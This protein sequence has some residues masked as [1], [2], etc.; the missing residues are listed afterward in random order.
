MLDT[1]EKNEREH[2]EAGDASRIEKAPNADLD[3]Y[4]ENPELDARL[5]RKFDFHISS[6]GFSASGCIAT[7]ISFNVALLVFYIPYI[8]VDVPCN[9]LVK[10]LRAGIYLPSLITVWGIVCMC[11]GFITNFA[12]LIACRLLL[13]L[14]EGGILGGVIIYLAMFYRRHAMMLRNGLFYCAAPL[15]GAFGGLLASGVAKIEVGGYDRW[16]RIFFIGGAMTVVFG[17][18]CYFF[19]PDTPAAA[20]FLTDEEKEWALLRVRID[21]GGSTRAAA[22][23]D[24]KFN[25]YWM[26][27]ALKSPQTYFCS[28]IWFFLLV[29]LYVSRNAK[30]RN[31]A[32]LC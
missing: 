28:F 1:K 2:F 24:E 15:S 19:M 8:L 12:G 29:P 20:G 13:G 4:A 21:A 22:V 18:I 23:D 3:S 5:N 27:M 10:R 6:R 30:V 14:F 32:G 17:I 25:S 26:K 9:L 16:P 11:T 7:G 31:R